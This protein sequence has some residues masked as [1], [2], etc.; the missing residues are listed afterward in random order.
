MACDDHRLRLLTPKTSEIAVIAGHKQHKAEISA[1]KTKGDI[2]LSGCIEG[3]ICVTSIKKSAITA[4]IE[5]RETEDIDAPI[6]QL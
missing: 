4:L 5:T 1:L 6:N 3:R 2:V